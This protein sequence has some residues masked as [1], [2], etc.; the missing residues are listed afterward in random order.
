MDLASTTRLIKALGDETRLRLLHLCSLGELSVSE[1]MEILNMGQSRVSTQLTL[2]KEVGLLQDRRLGRRSLY[3]LGPAAKGEPVDS[4]LAGHSETIEFRDDVAGW[5]ALLQRKEQESKSYF[6]R[7]ASTFGEQELPGRTWEG[8]ARALLHL[9]PRARYVDLGIGDG[10]LTLML[11][12]VAA[13]V[14]A[15]DLSPEMLS[16]LQLRAQK[17]GFSN[18]RYVE[19]RIEALPLDDAQF[20]VAVL[21]QAL[22]HTDDPQTTLEEARRVLVPGGTLI[23]IDLLAHNEDWVRERLQHRLLGFTEPELEQRLQ[24]AGFDHVRVS[25]VARDPSPPHFMTLLATG[26][27]SAVP[28]IHSL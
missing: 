15:V 27:A 3:S 19:G 24:Q 17:R 2:L 18:I 26:I 28:A 1:M 21:S 9:A 13:Q 12:E 14:T 7:V 8:L 23:V 6:D 4:L 25:R 11:A 22:H 10:L 20:D 16:Q 5:E